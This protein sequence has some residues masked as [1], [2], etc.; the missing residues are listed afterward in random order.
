[1]GSEFV[2]KYRLFRLVYAAPFPTRP[3]P[4]SM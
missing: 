3:K 2:L 4:S 1:M